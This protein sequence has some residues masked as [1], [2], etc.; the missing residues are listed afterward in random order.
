MALFDVIR[1]AMLAGFGMQ[2]KVREFIDDLVKKGELS[3]TQGAKLVREWSEKFEKNTTEI[4]KNI[5]DAVTKTLEKMKLSTKEDIVKLNEKV[6]S[7][8]ARIAKVEET[9]KE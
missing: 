5:S 9:K 2:E 6:D 8:S 1:N 3:E 7:L 4:S